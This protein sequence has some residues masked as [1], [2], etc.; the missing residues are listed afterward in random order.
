MSEIEKNINETELTKSQLA[1]WTGQ[2]MAP[3]APLYNTVYTFDIKNKL[4]VRVFRSAFQYLVK[5]TD[6]L[7]TVFN[8]KNTIPYQI[9]LPNFNFNLELVDFTNGFNKSEY[10]KWV[11]LRSQAKLNLA[12]CPFDS[13]LIKVNENRFVWFLNIHHIITDAISTTLLHE[14]MF[15]YYSNLKNGDENNIDDLPSFE[16]YI[17]FENKQSNDIQNH[18]KQ[19]YWKV[20]IDKSYTLPKLYGNENKYLKTASERITLGLGLDRSKRIK[21]LSKNMAVRSLTPRLTIFNLFATLLFTYVHRISNQNKITIGATA[22]NRVSQLFQKTPGL[23]IEIFPLLIKLEDQ[24][25]FLSVLQR[26][27]MET[28]DYLRNGQPGMASAD[29]SRGFNVILNYMTSKFALI[30]DFPMTSEWIHAGHND[31]AHHLRCHIYDFDSTGSLEIHL[32]FNTAVFDKELRYLAPKHFLCLID[33]MLDDINQH[34]TSASIITK[35]ERNELLTGDVISTNSKASV[36]AQFESQL[37][38]NPEKIAIRFK[39]QKLTYS[40]INNKTNQLANYLAK[41][42]VSKGDIVAIHLERS[43]NYIT[44]VLAA[45]K[46]G[47]TFVPI[48]SEQPKERVQYILQDSNCKA[49]ISNTVILRKLESKKINLINLD[50]SAEDIE[51]QT[52]TYISQASELDSIAYVIYTSGSTG[53]PK[54][55]MISNASLAN[56]INWSK[57][58]YAHKD[59]YVFPLCTSIGFDLTITATFLPLVT[60]GELI[61]YTESSIGPDISILQV[62]EDNLVNS[63]KLTP[64]HLALIKDSDFSS[65]KLKLII[66]GGEDFKSSLANSIQD[67]VGDDLK[68][69]NEYGPTEATVGCIVSRYNSDLHI[70]TSVPIGIPIKNMS[71]Y[72]LDSYHNLVPK[73]VIGE[74]YLSGTGLAKGYARNTK[75]SN[76]RF[77]VN[78]FQQNAKMYRT[79]DLVRFNESDELEYLGRVDEQVKLNGFRIELSDIEANLN[80]HPNINNAAVVLMD[81][82]KKAESKDIINCKECGLPSSYPNID[83][84]DNNVCHLCNSFKGYKEKTDK[85]FKTEEDLIQLLTSNKNDNRKYDCLTLLSGGKDSTY[86]LARLIDMGLNVLTFTLDNGYIS[87]QA[88]ANITRI[89]EKLGVDHIYGATPHMNKIFVDSLH[90][91]KNVCNGCFKTIY[92]LSTKVALENNIPFVV[93]GLSRGQFF[94][95]RLTEELFWDE[96]A[97]GTTIDDTILEARKLYHQEEDAVKNH[98]DTS[99]FSLDSTFNKVQYVDFYRYSN[100]SLTEML[101]FLKEKADWVR[102]TDTGRSTNCLINQAGI[103]VHK[104]ERGYSNYSFPYSWDVRLGHK[105]RDEALEEINEHIDEDEVHRM[106]DE[107]GYKKSD[108]DNNKKQLIGFYT[109]KEIIPSVDLKLHLAKHLPEYMFP[110]KYKHLKEMPLT[111]N[112]KIDKIALRT[113]SDIQLESDVVY[114]APTNEIEE[115]VE[116]I[117]KEV[118]QMDRIGIHDNFIS[119]GGH[120]LAAIRVTA[121]INDELQTNFAL[122]KIFELPT[123][124]EYAVY[125][126]SQ[127]MELLQQ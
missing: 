49:L 109:S 33:A 105:N 102:P 48:S 114:V 69:F 1:I 55:V 67:S 2:Q 90:R 53:K 64:S 15:E 6:I 96:D 47:T 89:T 41:Q 63:I 106:L 108:L 19:E 37:V 52:T 35:E 5:G 124:Q 80:Q 120:S 123:I 76:E 91:H 107:I 101:I 104:K 25:T 112:G 26:T 95:T 27:K 115:L 82:E 86:V 56:Y 88:K 103:H 17:T 10:Y 9:V 32:D 75:L 28:S 38:E 98:L 46:L 50:D 21:E 127:L 99:M 117:W 93:T 43:T 83:F 66:V 79:G 126:E 20:K 92:T 39:N 71:A 12:K 57:G 40:E 54:G 61:I 22:H 119:L 59:S 30:E 34:I 44:S 62:I 4:D 16:D 74:L 7:R 87:D 111:K 122:N 42:G 85:Y 45:L 31:P 8:T 113:L 100:V 94:E 29:I 18:L 118:L 36:I 13:A 77:L 125:I 97:D 110:S 3:D 72:V 121:R 65:S 84:D 70:E 78:P 81:S 60:G 68:I 11:E 58:Y 23:F 116:S 14:K 73:G 24:D 51:N